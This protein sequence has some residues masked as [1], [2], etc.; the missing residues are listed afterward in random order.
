MESRACLP[1]KIIEDQIQKQIAKQKEN[2]GS[3]DMHVIYRVK[4][5]DGQVK[6]LVDLGR[7]I[8][9]S[10]YGKVFFAFLEDQEKLAADR[11]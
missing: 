5:K 11:K 10:N 4:T 7:M 9:N 1:L 2:R 3:Y 8:D 6:R